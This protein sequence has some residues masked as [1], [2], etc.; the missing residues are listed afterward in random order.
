VATSRVSKGQQRSASGSIQKS[1]VCLQW[2]KASFG[3]PSVQNQHRPFAGSIKSSRPWFVTS[4]YPLWPNSISIP[5]SVLSSL[6]MVYPQWI[7][8][9]AFKVAPAE[10]AQRRCTSPPVGRC[11]G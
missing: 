2:G 8:L 4:P 5:H 11:V 7:T 9:L 1:N 10:V 6:S 3:E